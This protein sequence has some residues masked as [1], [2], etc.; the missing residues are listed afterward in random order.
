MSDLSINLQAS[1]SNALKCPNVVQFFIL[2]FSVQEIP[3]QKM[4]YLC[5]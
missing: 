5:L 3:R 1:I 4:S 2:V